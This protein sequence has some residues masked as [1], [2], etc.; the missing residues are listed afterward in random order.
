MNRRGRRTLAAVAAALLAA[1]EAAAQSTCA[2]PAVTAEIDRAL[3]QRRRGREQRALDQLRA[4]HARCPSPRA[5]AQM[6]LAEQGLRR[7]QDA[8]AHLSEALAAAR[9]PW[10]ASRRAVLQQSLDEVRERLPAVAPQT[11]VPGAE[12][13]VDGVLVGTLPLASPRVIPRGAATLELSAPGHR[14]LRRAVSLADGEVFR[15]PMNLE[16]VAR[17]DLAG[18]IAPVD[19]APAPRS[20]AARSAL[21]WGAIGLGAVLGGLA[22]W[23]GT[24]WSSQGGDT[25]RATPDSPGE[26]GA[27]AR[28]QDD[29]NPARALSPAE[30]CERARSGAT[31]DASG[32]RDLCD[33]SVL[34]AGLAW[35]LALGG[36]A[37]AAAGAVVL[38]TAPP[39]RGR[40]AW[41]VAPWFASGARGAT[42]QMDLW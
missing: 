17:P 8:Y 35:G 28:Y 34:H 24:S 2:E 16:P 20:S 27:W 40:T 12:L 5:L 10:I 41:R 39:T 38:A 4:L 15:E 13:R 30:V 32:A 21:G 7:W 19:A 25:A 31:S 9:D 18:P 6:A 29:V 33:A 1:G 14:T 3:E 37:L 11:N 36:V 26:L 23:Q 42:V 22:A